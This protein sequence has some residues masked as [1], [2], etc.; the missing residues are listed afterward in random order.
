MYNQ[1]KPAESLTVDVNRRNTL[2][3]FLSNNPAFVRNDM[4]R[5]LGLDR[6]A[7]A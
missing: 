7:A 5:A 3:E 1:L 4:P 2:K 6:R